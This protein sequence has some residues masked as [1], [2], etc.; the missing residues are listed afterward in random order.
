MK[1]IKDIL[2][3]FRD[4]NN[5]N[6]NNNNND[7]DH[8]FSVLREFME[9][10]PFTHVTTGEDEIHF[11][12]SQHAAEAVAH[13]LAKHELGRLHANRMG[14]QPMHEYFLSSTGTHDDV[15]D[16][17]TNHIINHP[18]LPRG[19]MDIVPDYIEHIRNSEAG[20]TKNINKY[21]SMLAPRGLGSEQSDLGAFL[22]R[23]NSHPDTETMGVHPH[24]YD[25][26]HHLQDVIQ[27]IKDN[28][29]HGY[30]LKKDE[31]K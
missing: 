14:N 6:N 24:L 9:K 3:E 4:N 1:K 22:V 8:P 15:L 28:D 10:T 23:K 16:A 2:K 11:N 18:K 31:Y 21:G 17:L 26:T 5:N 29:E 12:S 13:S 30:F 7:S 27:E 19:Y 20:K 25:D